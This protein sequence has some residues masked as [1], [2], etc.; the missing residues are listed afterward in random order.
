[1]AKASLVEVSDYIPNPAAL[2]GSSHLRR[3]GE[4][5]MIAEQLGFT[6]DAFDISISLSPH[7]SGEIVNPQQWLRELSLKRTS[8]TDTSQFNLLT[9][10]GL[11]VIERRI[12]D[13]HGNGAAIILRFD[14]WTRQNALDAIDG[15][16]A[17]SE[18]SKASDIADRIACYQ[19]DYMNDSFSDTL[20]EAYTGLIVARLTM[21][22]MM[23]NDDAK[24]S[25]ME[26][27]ELD[28]KEAMECLR[29]NMTSL[30]EM[31]ESSMQR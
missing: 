1:M 25:L 17:N 12:P 20:R 29:D 31:S 3:M 16:K 11:H 30:R 27:F 28:E 23:E 4:S 7:Q 8:R 9:L 18:H 5:A 24:L 14:D 6:P 13:R 2:S 10:P 21:L 15:N 19:S 26:A 22:G